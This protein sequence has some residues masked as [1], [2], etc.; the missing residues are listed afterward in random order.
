MNLDTVK[1]ESKDLQTILSKIG[2]V[3]GCV[4]VFNIDTI[5]S[6]IKN[7]FSNEMKSAKGIWMEFEILPSIPLLILND[8]MTFINNNIDENCEVLF[9]T[10]VNENMA[11]N[12]V[13]CKILFTGLSQ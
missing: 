3:A 10:V 1:N 9:E 11:E 4:K 8:I 12:S 2:K 13:K 7:E 5:T 6:D